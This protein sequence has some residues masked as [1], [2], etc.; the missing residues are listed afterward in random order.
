M[1][2]AGMNHLWKRIFIRRDEISEGKVISGRE[3]LSAE[4]KSAGM[5]HLWKRI[6]VGRDEI[7]EEK[8]YLGEDF[9]PQR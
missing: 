2:S 5:N 8:S 9:Y 6:F 4:M 3:F 1:K 7:N